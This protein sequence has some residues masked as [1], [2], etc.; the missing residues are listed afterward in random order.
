MTRHKVAHADTITL[1]RLRGAA[2]LRI[3]LLQ[4]K[5]FATTAAAAASAGCKGPLVTT[6]CCCMLGSDRSS[7]SH[8]RFH[9]TDH[10][11]S[12]NGHG[13]R[14]TAMHRAALQQHSSR[15]AAELPQHSHQQSAG[16]DGCVKDSSQI[17]QAAN[18]NHTVLS[19]CVVQAQSLA[20][21]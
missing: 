17:A 2:A 4:L 8:K 13:H 6:H 5:S 3:S 14:C 18:Q 15:A 12:T 20:E 10:N 9:S 1:I 16:D 21:R 19:T 7:S 11:L